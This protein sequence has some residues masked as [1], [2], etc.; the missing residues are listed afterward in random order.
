MYDRRSEL[1]EFVA[2]RREAAIEK[3]CKFF[4]VGPDALEIGDSEAGHVYGLGG[5]TVIVAGLKDRRRD[6]APPRRGRVRSGDGR[7]EGPPA[8]PERTSSR[9]ERAPARPAEPSVGTAQGSL[10][11]LGGFVLG[12]IERMNR[13]PFTISEAREAELTV[14]NLRGPAAEALTGADARIGEAIQLLAN[15]VAAR[16]VGENEEPPRVVVD[17]EGTGETRESF[18]SAMAERVA[19]RALETGRA[20]ALE[21]MNPRDRRAIHLALRETAGVATMSRGEGRYRQVVVVPE[22][23][24]EYEEA[25]RQ[26]AAATGA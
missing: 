5:R 8:R 3:A 18:L 11:E 13:G 19:R 4:G 24:P 7:G 23:A 2:D 20:V 21:P 22:G 9:V 26:T 17:L 14:I 15:Q 12:L 10:G 6:A 1:H 25:R 16:L